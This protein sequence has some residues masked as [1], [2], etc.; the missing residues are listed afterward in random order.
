VRDSFCE[1]NE[2]VWGV[3]DAGRT[4]ADP[5]L[6]LDVADLGSAYLGG[7]SFAELARAGRIEELRAGGV[8]RADALFRTE[9]TPWCPEVF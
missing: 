1:W 2:G 3:P 9:V 7:I 4:D 6:R 5:D 8:E